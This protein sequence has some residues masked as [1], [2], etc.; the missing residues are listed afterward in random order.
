M[1]SKSPGLKNIFFALLPAF[2][3][4]LVIYSSLSI[5][6]Y[7]TQ[8]HPFDPFLQTY[9]PYL[10]SK[11]LKKP[12]NVFRVLTLGGSTTGNMRLPQ[13]KRYPDL[14][15]SF[16]Q[17]QYKG[18]GIELF[19]AGVDWYTTKHSLINYVTNMRD[20]QPDLVVVM[21]AINDLYRSFSPSD[22]AVEPYNRLWSHFYGPS[23]KGAKPP[24]FEQYW[25][26][27]LFSR[28]YPLTGNVEREIPL[29]AFLSLKD[30]EE[31]LRRLVHFI[32]S[33]NV[34]I[35]L[36]TQPSLYKINMA[37]DEMSVLWIG[38]TFCYSKKSFFRREYPSANTLR[39]AMQAF[40]DVTRNTAQL[41]KVFFLDLESKI[42]KNLKNFVDDIHYT[43]EGAK[44]VAE[45]VANKII[46]ITAYK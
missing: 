23:I 28:W 41:E 39:I 24:T 37:T 8:T 22:L 30:F 4:A 42:E 45:V 20:F 1:K 25:L 13:G 35:I 17:E 40:N 46:Q 6:Y 9:P 18:S 14:L 12:K 38:K 15:R 26:R 7:Y 36:M 19:N 34:P 2:V 31:N 33:D 16:L 11:Y 21:H 32:K 43:E 10:D 3:L 27:K 29:D 44:K 5:W